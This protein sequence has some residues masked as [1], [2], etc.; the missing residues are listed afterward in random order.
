MSGRLFA[1]VAT[2]LAVAACT[3]WGTGRDSVSSVCYRTLARVDCYA[4]P[5]PGQ[6]SRRV[7]SYAPYIQ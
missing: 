2:A 7:G 4:T 6:E 3:G 1:V 5:V